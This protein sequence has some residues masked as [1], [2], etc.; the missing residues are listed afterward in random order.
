MNLERDL[1]Q[2]EVYSETSR[3]RIFVG[4]LSYDEE[5]DQYRFMYDK[6]Y[7]ASSGAIPLGPEI[8]F[9]KQTHWSKGKLFP[10]FAER[11]PSKAN[12]AY[13][14]YCK[15]QGIAPT[16]RNP[17]VLL[18]T[19]GR[20]GPST[21]VFES[22]PLSSFDHKSLAK[23]RKDLGLSLREFSIAFSINLLTLHHLE[24]GSSKN[25]SLL[26]LIQVYSTFPEVSLWQLE[27][28]GRKLHQE[29]LTRLLNYFQRHVHPE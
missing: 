8:G 15:S 14:E 25:V 11:I 29:T 21:F 23:F 19:I 7:L 17:I 22:I 13:K 12:P 18:T 10:S 26:K 16:E 4:V 5:R 28:T 3:K 20:R 9:T 2:L 24:K 27:T 6:K 1:N